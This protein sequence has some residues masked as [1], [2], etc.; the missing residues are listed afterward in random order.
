MPRPQVNP[1]NLWYKSFPASHIGQ[2]LFRLGYRDGGRRPCPEHYR[3]ICG[4]TAVSTKTTR[5]QGQSRRGMRSD[6]HSSWA[7][8]N[9]G[10]R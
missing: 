10:L 9:R 8:E 4:A 2:D 6:I 1:P 3:L 5:L 7:L